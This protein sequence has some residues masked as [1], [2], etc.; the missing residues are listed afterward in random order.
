[1]MVLVHFYELMF[2]MTWYDMIWTGSLDWM[3]LFKKP[4]E[5]NASNESTYVWEG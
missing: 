4:V 2:D 5:K 3:D 1:M